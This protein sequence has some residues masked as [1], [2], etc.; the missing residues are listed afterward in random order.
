MSGMES[1]VYDKTH[2]YTQDEKDTLRERIWL[3]RGEYGITIPMPTLDRILHEMQAM[4]KTEV[5]GLILEYKT[6]LQQY[7][8]QAKMEVGKHV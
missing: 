6:L 4:P 5:Q 2:E 1:I 7:Q 8:M 3:L